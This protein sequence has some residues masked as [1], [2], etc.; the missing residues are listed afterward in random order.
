M[1]IIIV[2]GGVIGC[3]V[4]R[5]LSRYKVD[6]TLLESHNDVACGASKAN[7]GIA[8]AGYDATSGSLKAMFNVGGNAMFDKLSQDLNFS[9]KR[10]GSMVL[11]MD[12]DNMPQLEV[13]R[14]R[15]IANGVEGL[16]ILNHEQV[17]ALNHNI[18]DKVVG[19]LY[20]P[21]AGIVDPYGMT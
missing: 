1:K 19:A 17:L 11:C 2:G 3:A 12:N 15:G 9:F 6:V 7:S 18:S 21:S 16:Q 5:E 4:A 8:H 10:N 20:A 14:S 13:L